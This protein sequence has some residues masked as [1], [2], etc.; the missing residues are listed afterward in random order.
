MSQQPAYMPRVVVKA[1]HAGT[2][3]G[4]LIELSVKHEVPN[5]VLLAKAS[6][7]YSPAF[8]WS[9][10]LLQPGELHADTIL[11]YPMQAYQL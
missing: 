1:Q 11:C 8:V 10:C 7:Q 4:P 6:A 9:K 2:L 5:T 3:S